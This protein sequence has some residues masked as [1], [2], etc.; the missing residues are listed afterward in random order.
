MVSVSV[1]KNDP[2]FI[3]LPCNFFITVCG[4]GTFSRFSVC[5]VANMSL[6]FGDQNK[7]KNKDE[8]IFSNV[9]FLPVEYFD[10]ET[11]KNEI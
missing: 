6:K 10:G 7:K 2:Y 5:T 9:C 11:E 4:H 8:I 3:Q 1:E